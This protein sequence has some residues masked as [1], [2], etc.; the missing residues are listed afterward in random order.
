MRI[1][2]L[3][4][5]AWRTGPGCHGRR[6]KTVSLL[7]EGLLRRGVEVNLFATL[8]SETKGK[9]TAV[10][11]SGY[12]E[13]PDIEPKVWE[14]LHVSE[15]FERGEEFDLIHNHMDYLPLTYVRLIS[16]PVVTTLYG[17]LPG[18]TL[19]IY[20]KYNGQAFYVATSDAERHPELD[21]IA[22][23]H[24]GLDDEGFSAEK[25]VEDYLRVYEKILAQRHR[26]DHRP[27]GYYRVLED[28]PDHKVKRLVVYP[29][30]RL[31]LQRHQHR[32]E[33]WQ[34]VQGRAIITRNDDTLRPETGQAVGIPLRAWHRIENQGNENLVL[35]E[36]QTG[37][38]FGED[39]IE[40]KEDDFGRA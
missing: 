37:D 34:I 2:M 7:T 5:I 39:D 38:Y 25:M 1:A 29:G 19:P 21:Y 8:D 13:G 12:E 18:A 20:T 30:K 4:P 32:A 28:E 22:A 35:I 15:L 17:I 40:R 6:E 33:L 31:S 9:L 36:V 14:A 10:C 24:H 26:E 27:W 16:T 23:I 3:S 11:P